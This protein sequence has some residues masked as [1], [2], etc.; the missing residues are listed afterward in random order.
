[1]SYFINLC[2]PEKIEASKERILSSC[3]IGNYINAKYIVF[4]P[5]Y[6][7][8]LSAEEAYEFVRKGCIELSKLIKKN[9]LN[10]FLGLETTGK[11][12]QFGTLDEILKICKEI[13]ICRP[14]VDFA[15]IYAR[16]GGKINYSE[17]FDKLEKFSYLHTHFSGIEFTDKG[18]RRHIPISSKHPDFDELAKE[19]VNRGFTTK[20][21]DIVIISE[22]PVLEQ[23]SLKMMKILKK[24][25]K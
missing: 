2:N 6:Y 4:H 10:V 22:S 17:I 24:Y 23:D 1:A 16:N 21:R 11:K 13:K 8:N 5:G 18:E 14:V 12:S 15:H 9:K 7:G 25:E 3:V 20:K 19:L